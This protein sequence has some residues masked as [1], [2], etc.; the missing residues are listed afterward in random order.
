MCSSGGVLDLD[1]SLD[2]PLAK[3][4]P[5]INGQVNHMFTDVDNSYI[6]DLYKVGCVRDFAANIYEAF[7]YEGA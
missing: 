4:I 7:S 3:I 1:Q 5:I 6:E 2:L